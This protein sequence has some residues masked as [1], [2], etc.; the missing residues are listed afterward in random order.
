MTPSGRRGRR[1]RNDG[2][3]LTPWSVRVSETTTWCPSGPRR[4]GPSGTTG[5]ILTRRREA[6][7]VALT[8]VISH[9]RQDDA[10]VV[11]PHTVRTI[12]RTDDT[13]HAQVCSSPAQ[14]LVERVLVIPTPHQRPSNPRLRLPPAPVLGAIRAQIHAADVREDEFFANHA[15]QRHNAVTGA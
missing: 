1:R 10:V 5:V 11:T 14:E 6:R 3:I 2:V 7:S 9:E 8:R 13:A 12:S 4:D 15:L